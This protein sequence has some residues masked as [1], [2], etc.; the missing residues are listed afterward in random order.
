MGR[1]GRRRLRASTSRSSSARTR[2]RSGSHIV[3]VVR[4]DDGASDLLFQTSDTTWQAYNQ[5]GG[6][7]LYVGSPAGRALQGELQPPVHD[8]RDAPEDWSSTPSTRWSAGSS[9]TATTSATSTGVD[10][11]RR[12]AELLEHEVF[13]SVGHD[14]YWS[15]EQRANVEAARAAGVNLAFFSG[16]EVFWKTRWEPSIDGSATPY[17]T[18]VSYKETHAERE[19][20]SAAERWTGTWR[21]SR[22]FNPDGGRARERADRDDL[23]GQLRRR[24]RRSR[25]P[26]PT[27]SCASGA[28]RHRDLDAGA[29]ATLPAERSGYEWDED[30]DNGSRP[31]GLF[32]CRRPPRRTSGAPGPRL[33]VRAGHGDAPT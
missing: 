26:R 7:S 31:A 29:T 30:L 27:G 6:N 32:R 18:L 5:Y 15:G 21:D 10:T 11:D 2:Q 1:A 28:T 3:F 24:L 16:N 20:R 19:D 4:D 33:D 17:R 9:A 25:C 12:G 13:L 14:E 23:H 22:G 8:A